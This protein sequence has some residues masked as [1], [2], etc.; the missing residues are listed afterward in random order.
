MEVILSANNVFVK[1]YETLMEPCA[2]DGL[3]LIYPGGP[4]V[5]W[6]S[7]VFFSYL[8]LYFRGVCVL[9]L[10]CFLCVV[11]WGVGSCV[12]GWVGACVRACVR[13]CVCVRAGGGSAFGGYGSLKC[14]FHRIT[15]HRHSYECNSVC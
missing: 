10:F 9:S 15:P 12:G 1:K 13:A 8:F 5:A 14:V 3:S 7:W 11:V 2:Q 6:L 4:G